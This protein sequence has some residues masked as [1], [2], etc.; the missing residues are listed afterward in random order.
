[1]NSSLNEK[2][3]HTLEYS[4]SSKLCGSILNRDQ[5]PQ[6]IELKNRSNSLDVDQPTLRGRVFNRRDDLKVYVLN[7]NG[8]PLMPCEPAIARLLL[9]QKKAKV[10]KRSPF[11]IQLKYDT[12][13][14]IQEINLGI[15]SGYKNIGFSVI[16]EKEELISGEVLLEN[17]M[18]KRLQDRAMYRRNRRNR[19][20][21]RE[22]RFLNRV[23]SK[24]KGW[25]PPSIERRFNTHLRIIEQI[26]SILPISKVIVEVAK[27]DIQKLE[28]SDIEGAEYQQGDMY[29]YR[30]RISYL[31][32]RE[33]GRCQYCGKEYKKG[34]GWRLHHIWGKSKDR[35]KDWALVHESCHKKLHA[36]NEEHILQKQ[37]SKSYKEST[38]MSIIKKRF[39]KM[40]D[41]TYGNITFQNRCDLNL[42][43]SHVNDAFVIAGGTN[44]ER[45]TQFLVKQKRKNNRCLQ[46]NRKGFKPS[47]RKQRY[48]LQPKDLVKIKNKV[49]EVAG[50]HSYGSQVKLKDSAGNIIN[51]AIKKLDEYVFHQKTLIWRLSDSSQT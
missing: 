47:I 39:I 50:V 14:Y 27:F 33:K 16:S 37:K 21:Y 9:K 5:W 6:C 51:K 45:C 15:D 8:K 48:L 31:I 44:Q 4:T 34:D 41:Y 25:L 20:W 30:N 3:I 46:L 13:E 36:K 24:K 10:V 35:S 7:M 49:Y 22:P 23:F 17:N 29:Q 2:Y 18:S 43:K 1:M 42:E 19:L 38:F 26:K 11:T 12:T 28:N 40:F 32:A